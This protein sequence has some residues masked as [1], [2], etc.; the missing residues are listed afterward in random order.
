M[1]A[2]D[3]L[4]PRGLMKQ[5]LGQ[6]WR[7]LRAFCALGGDATFIWP[8]WII[9]RAVGLVYVIIFCSTMAE[10]QA[11]LGP[12]GVA[13]VRNVFA[14]LAKL[15]PNPVEAFLRAPS[16]FWISTSAGMITALEWLGLAAAVAVVLNLWPRL[17]LSACWVI[18]LSFA[19]SGPFFS[20]TAPDPLLLEVALLCIPFAP[21][22]LRPGLGTAAAPRPVA[23]LAL[24][25][26]LL[27]IMVEAGLSKFIYGSAE[28]HNLTAMD[29][30]YETAPFPTVLAY[31]DHQLPH[32]YHVLEIA[33]TFVAEIPAPLVM[34]FG[35]RRWR[36]CAFG[37]WLVFQ[38]GIELTNNFGWLQPSSIALAVILLDDQMLVGAF[39]RFRLR[40]LGEWLAARVAAVSARPVRPWA[41]WGLRVAVGG[42]FLL[43]M[44]YYIV[45]PTRIPIERVPAVI[46]QPLILLSAGFHCTNNFPLFGTIE[47]ARY[48]VEFVGTNDGGET[49]RSYDSRYQAQRTDRMPPFIAPWYPRLDALLENKLTTSS[50]PA[51]YQAVAA[52][53]LKRDPA[54]LEIFRRDPFADRPAT[55]IRMQTYRLWFTDAA[56]F[57]A[58]G[59]YWRKAYQG[60]YAPM[61]YLNAQGEI[62]RTE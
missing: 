31:W 1:Q 44:F 22:G 2:P 47:T 27:R 26:L 28:W 9:L 36:W 41:R 12:D 20:I 61:M 49:W 58:T 19:N 8:R 17:A 53:L 3:D 54:V 32:V 16:L 56:T 6:A 5:L 62:V 34:I 11:L 43:A 13:P 50:D 55:M 10:S 45:A 21:P 29:F 60:E 42:Q 39:R 38:G 7:E 33:L 35:G 18:F 25:L 15:Y 52:H 4:V 37:V 46:S 14:D 24:R 23:V 48:E 59:N 40:R 30:M 51:L 57:R